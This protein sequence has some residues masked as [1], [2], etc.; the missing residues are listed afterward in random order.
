MENPLRERVWR[1]GW[2]EPREGYRPTKA[3]A[4]AISIPEPNNRLNSLTILVDGVPSEAMEC[5]W[6]F[7]I[8]SE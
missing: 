2:R 6:S 5:L 8:P 3:D 7:T 1:E 4:G